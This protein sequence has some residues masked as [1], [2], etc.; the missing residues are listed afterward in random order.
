[1]I[2]AIFPQASRLALPLALALL[3]ASG[4]RGLAQPVPS[5]PTL[6]TPNLSMPTQGTPTPGTPPTST[7]EATPAAPAQPQAFRSPEQGVA[8]L[9]RA[10]RAQ[11]ERALLRI[12][13]EAGRRIIRSGDPVVDRAARERFVAAY[14]AKH[15][16]LRPAAGRAV[17]QVGEDGW[18]LPIPLLAR[19]G[20]WRF[21][22]QAGAQALVD[23]RIG[24]NEL[25][26]IE[27]L[28]AI[29]EAQRDYARTAGRQGGFRAYARRFFSTPGARDGLF[30]ASAEGEPESPLGPLLAAASAGGYG[31]AGQG[32]GQGRSRG[33]G[34]APRPFHGYLFRILDRQGPA[35]PGGAM[36][37][38]VDGRMIGGFAVIAWPAAWG[39]TGIKTFLV[40][41]DG[42]VW[43]SNL[44][45]QTARAA[46]AITAF[47]PGP[48]WSR[49]AE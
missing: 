45:P 44:G 31:T 41:H 3:L 18:P 35:A 23:R 47:D 46:A 27:T 43:E 5:T 17:L 12:L 14:D 29:V 13:G 32:Q 24:R 10:M 26:T 2:R 4:A 8:A 33:E 15:E 25:D 22:A 11:D 49:V 34:D 16:I 30:W 20:A 40:S 37:Y 6:S 38:V 36:E 9:V 21:D 39:S 7:A 1:M 42:V 48:G 28:R 19:G